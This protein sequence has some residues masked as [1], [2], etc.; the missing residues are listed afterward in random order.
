MCI[1]D[2]AQS[3]GNEERISSVISMS[4][5]YSCYMG[6]LCIGVFTMFGSQLGVSVFRD[7]DAGAFITILALS[8]IHIYMPVT[9]SFQSDH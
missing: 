7:P 4:L 3:D 5:R 6:I 8:L 2:R 9:A 1:R